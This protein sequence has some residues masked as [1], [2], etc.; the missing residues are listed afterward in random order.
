MVDSY[1]LDH[2]HRM[3][4]PR[5]DLPPAFE[6]QMQQLLGDQYVDFLQSLEKPSPVST[7]LNP[8]KKSPF[9]NTPPVPWCR[10]GRYLDQRPSFTLDPHLHGGGYYVQEASS[11]FI[12]Q[13]LTQ[14][15]DLAQPLRVLDLCAAPGGKSTHL[16]S[17]LSADSLLVSNEAIRSRATVLAE[18]IQKWG[19]ANVIV[20]NNDP[21][22][23]SSLTGYF[24][25]ILID[26]PCSGEGLFR[27]DPD[28]IAEWSPDSVALCS[29]RQR[30]IVEDAL[31][32][33]KE[34]GLLIYCT[35]TY[36]ESENE[37]N[38]RWLASNQQLEF[39]S[40]QHTE[41]IQEVNESVING[42]H[43]FPHRIVGEGFFI[44]VMRKTEATET[45]HQRRDKRGESKVAMP[46]WLKGDFIATKHNDLVIA[47][48]HS[49]ASDML[50]LAQQLN[51]VTRGIA[52]CT[53]K[54]GKLIPEHAAALSVDL[55]HSKFPLLD[56]TR[57]QALQ[58]LR[59]DVLTI[60][61]A[62]KGFC[63][64]RFE[65]TALGWVN[66][67]DRRINNLYPSGWRVR[68]R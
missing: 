23:F 4:A 27:K 10:D 24:D 18:N 45:L 40:L 50:W 15:I 5:P 35:C 37:S 48:P 64:V 54:H 57:D 60:D 34:G 59:K 17:L 19:H 14:T 13:A 46:D 53:E 2:Q 52:L 39:I 11:M 6:K 16:L 63:L 12:E 33:L 38:L 31:P 43:F 26:A 21:T 44:S 8:R 66:V 65:D 25:V 28:A 56:L 68:L 42:Y 7:R 67:L 22:A 9:G 32:A 20:T 61:D 51:I 62:P 29:A 47:L 58:Y 41:G 36:N 30:R 55:D 49:S 3:T 1:Y